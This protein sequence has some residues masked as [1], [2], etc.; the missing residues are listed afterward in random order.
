MAE[1]INPHCAWPDPAP[2]RGPAA[3]PSPRAQ[4]VG[5]SPLKNGK[6]ICFI[7]V[8]MGIIMVLMGFIYS[9]FHGIHS[10]FMRFIVV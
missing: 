7:V 8:L 10:G 2:Q 3:D 9:C 1:T 5:S 4:Y 6:K